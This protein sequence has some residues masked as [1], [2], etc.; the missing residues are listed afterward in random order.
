MG[1][2]VGEINKLYNFLNGSIILKF[3]IFQAA[4]CH[5]PAKGWQAPQ[6]VAGYPNGTKAGFRPHR[7]KR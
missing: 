7:C 5:R 6:W 3:I 1:K 4:L 2:G